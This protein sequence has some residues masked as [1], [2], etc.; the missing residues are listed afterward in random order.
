MQNSTNT[1]LALIQ[2]QNTHTTFIFIFMSVYLLSSDLVVV[3]SPNTNL[4][5]DTFTLIEIKISCNMRMTINH[6]R[7][8]LIRGQNLKMSSAVMIWKSI[9]SAFAF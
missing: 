1:Q 7:H 9:S 4:I 6:Q 3:H 8:I 5:S 2:Q